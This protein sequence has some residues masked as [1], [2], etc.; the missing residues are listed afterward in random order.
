MTRLGLAKARTTF[1]A[2]KPIGFTF[3]LVKERRGVGKKTAKSS[4]MQQKGRPKGASQADRA[5]KPP[6]PELH[7]ISGL[8]PSGSQSVAKSKELCKRRGTRRDGG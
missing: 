6:V 1:G 4:V 5:E 2:E 3:R 7:E 8:R